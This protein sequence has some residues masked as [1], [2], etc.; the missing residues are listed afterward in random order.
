MC[1]C[2]EDQEI[3]KSK[4]SSDHKSEFD[5]LADIITGKLAIGLNTKSN[6][7]QA[8]MELSKLSVP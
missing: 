2:E 7:I 3:A 1:S 4:S 8:E 6:L 5:A